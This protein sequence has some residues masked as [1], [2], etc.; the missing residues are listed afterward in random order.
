M[1]TE[2]NLDVK[3]RVAQGLSKEGWPITKNLFIGEIPTDLTGN[4]L[5]L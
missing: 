3:I 1:T 5:F 4:G 2:H